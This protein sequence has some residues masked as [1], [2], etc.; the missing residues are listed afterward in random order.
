MALPKPDPS[1]YRGGSTSSIY[2]QDLLNWQQTQQPTVEPVGQEEVV[3]LNSSFDEEPDAFAP[4]YTAPPVDYVPDYV[5]PEVTPEV[6]TVATATGYRETGDTTTTSDPFADY[7]RALITGQD[8]SADYSSDPLL[9]QDQR[10]ASDLAY[11]DYT[12]DVL[13]DVTF[14]TVEARG[15]DYTNFGSRLISGDTEEYD[16]VYSYNEMLNRGI[17]EATAQ[18]WLDSGGSANDAKQIIAENFVNKQENFLS[19][20]D[21]TLETGTSSEFNQRYKDA[22]LRGK[23]AIADSLRQQGT[24]TDEQ[25]S[26]VYIDEWNASQEGKPN[27]RFIIKTKAPKS[28]SD[29]DTIYRGED[30]FNYEAGDDIYVLYDPTTPDWQQDETLDVV[31]PRSFF[32]PDKD[33]PRGEEG[34]LDYYDRFSPKTEQ[35]AYNSEWVSFRDQ[36]LIPGART[37]LAAATGGTSEKLYSAVKLASGETLHGSDY[38][39]LVIGGLE[40]AGVIGNTATFTDPVTGVTHTVE[41]SNGLLGLGYDQTVGVIEAIGNQDVVGLVTNIVDDGMITGAL[42]DIGLPTNLA[43]DPD[44]ISG[45]TEAVTTIAGG[46]DLSEAVEDGFVEYVTEGG[47]FGGLPETDIDIDLG[48]ITDVVAVISD[49]VGDVTS[50]IGDYVDPLLQAAGDTL[51]PVVDEVSEV[52]GDVS[53]AIGD[54]TDPITSTIGD[55]GSEVE[56]VVRDVGSEIDDTIIEPAKEFV[57]SIETPDVDLPSIDLPSIDLNLQ[58]PQLAMPSATRTTD[59]LFSDELFKFKTKIGVTPQQAL[60][61]APRRRQQREES[62]DLFEDLFASPFDRN[63]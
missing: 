18:E 56:D 36:F 30:A 59:S 44:F 12:D 26:Q 8:I 49:T 6:E 29:I 62:V 10:D 21:D 20:I 27:P 15:G 63:V 13:S 42:E 58:L 14:D 37:V 41:A 48:A 54:V 40:Q 1:R 2:K 22:D 25:F 60:I 28:S 45:V 5:E 31:D 16:T 32:P 19:A 4:I 33:N 47:G 46:G 43:N 38:A 57:E 51:E 53:S 24:L 7:N 23:I 55:V 39:N 61:E 35:S 3:S 9:S 11:M 52:I 34:I 17:D 50:A